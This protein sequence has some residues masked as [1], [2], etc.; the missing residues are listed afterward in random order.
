MTSSTLNDKPNQ[1]AVALLKRI[2]DGATSSQVSLSE[3]LRLCMRLGQVLDNDELSKWAMAEARGYNDASTLPEYRIFETNVYGTFSGWGGSSINNFLIPKIVVKPEHHKALFEVNLMQSVG[4][5]ER[6]VSNG[7]QEESVSVPWSGD[8]VAYYQRK[9]FIQGYV[10]VAA[11]RRFTRA[12]IAGVLEVIR[13]RVLEFVLAIEKEFGVEVNTNN[14]VSLVEPSGQEKV[15]QMFQTIIYGG[16]NVSVGSSGTVNQQVVNVQ[17]GDLS[18][19]KQQLE[20]LG[21][22]PTLI[23]ELETAF[24]K[25]QD[26]EEQPGPATRGWLGRVMIMVGK[27]TL[28]L[29]S[30]VAATVITAEIRK[31]LGLPPA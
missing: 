4:E 27:G 19:L 7:S 12:T 31:F 28:Q 6:L 15:T 2:V 9:E 18:G 24:D 30:T 22:T 8:T 10:L 20:S 25:D 16:E 29:T 5:L 1:E 3:V 23:S 13:T 11:S 14:G 17:P 26:S 21:L